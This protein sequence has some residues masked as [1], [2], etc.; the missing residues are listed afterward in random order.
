MCKIIVAVAAAAA[1]VVDVVAVVA[2][3]RVRGYGAGGPEAAP[4]A[5]GW[6][7]EQPWPRQAFLF[8]SSSSSSFFFF[9]SELGDESPTAALSSLH[10]RLLPAMN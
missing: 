3:P 6:L 4:Q 1:V 2:G 7:A 8:F 5:P 10:P 9:L